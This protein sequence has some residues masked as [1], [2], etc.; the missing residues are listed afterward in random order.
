[1]GAGIAQV[2]VNNGYPTILKDISQT[3]LVRGMNQIDSNLSKSVK[4]K[5]M[6]RLEAIMSSFLQVFFCIA[7]FIDLILAVKKIKSCQ[8]YC[9]H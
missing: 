6:S 9:R 8:A 3:A 2:S 5:K 1:M 7:V 4:R